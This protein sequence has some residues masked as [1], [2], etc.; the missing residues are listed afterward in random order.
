HALVM[1]YNKKYLRL[2]GL[3]DHQDKPMI[4]PG[5]EGFREFLD[6]IKRAVPDDIAPM[7]Q[8]STRIDSA[9]LWWSLYNQME[10]GGT[11]FSEDGKESILNNPQAVEALTYVN[12]L[13]QHELIPPNINDAFKMFYDDKAAVLITGMWGTGAFE[14]NQALDIGIVPMPV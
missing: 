9:W 13:Y 2:A 5:P 7:A 11:F 1:Y 6:T 8:P 4:P 14:N 12:D 10:D 3:L